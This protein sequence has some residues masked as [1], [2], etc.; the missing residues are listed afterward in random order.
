MDSED[1]SMK[2]QEQS[3]K[4]LFGSLPFEFPGHAFS[5]HLR[6]SSCDF[7]AVHYVSLLKHLFVLAKTYNAV[8]IKPASQRRSHAGNPILYLGV[9]ADMH[10]YRRHFELQYWCSLYQTDIAYKSDRLPQEN[11]AMRAF[12]VCRNFSVNGGMLACNGV[13]Q[14]LPANGGSSR[15]KRRLILGHD[16]SYFISLKRL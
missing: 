1:A 16:R 3:R 8:L 12:M 11:A 9:A 6:S 10:H 14:G 7:N 13:I 5:A 2:H 4:I 15:H